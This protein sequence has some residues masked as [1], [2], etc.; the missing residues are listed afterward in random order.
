VGHCQDTIRVLIL[1]DIRLYREGLA[2]LLDGR[3]AF[4][5]VGSAASLGETMAGLWKAADV[6]LLDMA[7][8]RSLEAARTIAARE[9][10][11]RVV[12]IAVPEA[13][14][15]VVACA[16]AGVSGYVTRDDSSE[17][18]AAVIESVARGELLA[19]PRIAAVLLRRVNSL[20]AAS[21]P[22]DYLRLTPREHEIVNL[23]DQGF[24]NK[25][26]ARH[27]RIELATVKNH[28]HNILEKLQV[29][30]RAEAAHRLRAARSM[31]RFQKLDSAKD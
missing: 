6:V 24:S 19:T 12:A 14:Q 15:D 22:A 26:I 21:D 11:P 8:P 3:P 17:T 28:V 9:A 7:M 20:A 27:L 18:M 4:E 2:L 23:I 13:D 30:G 25:A 1:A 31:D 10:A 29:R 16:E 5:V